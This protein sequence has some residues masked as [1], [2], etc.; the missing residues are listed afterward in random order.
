M[1]SEKLEMIQIEH[2]IQVTSFGGSGSTMLLHYLK[3]VGVSVQQD[4]DHT[5]H[6][7]FG[8]WK[9]MPQP[10]RAPQFVL[11]P[12]F[13]CL[14]LLSN[15]IDA[16]LSIFRREFH[17][18]HAVRM[19]SQ[20]NWPAGWQLA[21]C[22]EKPNWD[23]SDFL[24]LKQDNFGIISHVAAWT[25]RDETRPYPIMLVKYEALWQRRDEVLAYLGVPPQVWDSFPPQKQRNQ[26]PLNTSENRDGLRNVYGA[27]E[28]EINAMDDLVI[29]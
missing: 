26:N 16:L 3:D 19:E 18:W 10:P 15:P 11:P 25:R 12:D 29:I 27:L 7:D 13:R 28:A 2:T 24:A 21:D 22:P 14:Y 23:L 17:M 1:E 5:G 4:Y 8:L 6:D 9:H 20:G